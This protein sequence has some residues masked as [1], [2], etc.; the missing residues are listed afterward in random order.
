MS[1]C[2]II[3]QFGADSP[4]MEEDDVGLGSSGRRLQMGS[5]RS[6]D[7]RRLRFVFNSAW[8]WALV[9]L[10]GYSQAVN[11]KPV[12]YDLLNSHFRHGLSKYLHSKSAG[13]VLTAQGNELLN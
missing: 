3:V 13:I 5:E 11:P 4:L 2:L 8:R 12:A 9:M 6:A 10:S 7:A 1:E